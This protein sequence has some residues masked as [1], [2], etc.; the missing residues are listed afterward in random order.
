MHLEQYVHDH[1]GKLPNLLS[2]LFL[3]VGPSRSSR[4]RNVRDFGSSEALSTVVINA[5]WT[6]PTEPERSRSREA[7]SVESPQLFASLFPSFIVQ[8]GRDPLELVEGE[9]G[10]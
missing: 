4:L 10:R 8:I 7:I 5:I 2:R 9:L 6:N 1:L 3:R